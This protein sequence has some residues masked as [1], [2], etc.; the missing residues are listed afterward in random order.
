LYQMLHSNIGQLCR[1]QKVEV[2]EI[3]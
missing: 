1:E 2:S 3:G